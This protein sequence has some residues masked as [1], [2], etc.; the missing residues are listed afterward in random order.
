MTEECVIC[1]DNI[2]PTQLA[3][4]D[5]CSHVYHIT[6]INSWNDTKLCNSKCSICQ[7]TF[8]KIIKENFQT[9]CSICMEPVYDSDRANIDSCAHI[10]HIE[11]VEKWKKTK[12]S[13]SKCSVCKKKFTKIIYYRNT[14]NYVSNNAKKAKLAV[15]PVVVTDLD[16]SYLNQNTEDLNKEDI[17]EISVLFDKIEENCS[18]SLTDVSSD[19]LEIS[20]DE[21]NVPLSE[22]LLRS[23]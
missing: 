4:L 7:K 3:K 5:C 18:L 13:K 6:C 8:S 21:V 23:S 11:C 17:V 14:P 10:Y 15:K 12:I 1:L 16:L 22:R 20:D 2:A 19:D 9:D